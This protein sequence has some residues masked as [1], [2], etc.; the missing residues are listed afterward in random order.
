[1][2]NTENMQINNK[3]ACVLGY[4]VDLVLKE[5]ALDIAENY[6]ANGKGIHVV[7]IN[8]EIILAAEK[9]L[10][11]DSIIKKAELI[12]PDSSGMALALKRTGN[13]H[14][15]KLAGIEFSEALI[16]RCSQKG[17]KVAFL[18]ASEEVI[19]KMQEELKAKYPQLEIAYARNG[20]FSD[21]D[22]NNISEEI[23]NTNPHLLLV[24]LGAPR[25]EYIID[26][27]REILPN[28][29]MIGVGGSFDVWAKKV[30]RAP[31][32]FRIFGLEWLYRLIKQ[33]SR[34]SRMFPALPLFIFRTAIM[35]ENSRK[36]Y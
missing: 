21:D 31:V 19:N 29:T 20:Y 32:I 14:I 17:F 30:N 18:G 2:E 8:P 12:I 5:E 25:Q 24:A 23:K 33:P 26:K 3:R 22:L 16:A 15:K 35:K 4:P 36:V 27:F 28:T 11:L 34:F 9:N 6:M 13:G 7:T 10:Q 1:M